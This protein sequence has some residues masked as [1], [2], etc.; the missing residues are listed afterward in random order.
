MSLD[1]QDLDPDPIVQF[2][3]W[4][5]EATAAGVYQPD[6]VV[7]AT[8]T[9]TG[10]PSA[11]AVLLRDLD[12]RGFVFFTGYGSRKARELIEN[13]FASLVFGWYQVQRQVRVTGSVERL[14]EPASDFYWDTRPRGSQLAAWASLQSEPV[15]SRETLDS[16]YAE[17]EAEYDGRPVPR[18]ERWGGFRLRHD[19][20]ELWQQRPNRMH[21]RLCYVRDG[22]G[23]R[24]ERLQ[25]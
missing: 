12:D 16:R 23:W 21:D 10:R 13:P 7:L 17:L 25:P 8:A 3:R 5:D 2:R 6:A 24:I 9:S 22:E 15:D 11:R 1:E 19:T 20:L 14:D 4:L 18:P